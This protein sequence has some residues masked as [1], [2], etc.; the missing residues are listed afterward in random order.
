MKRG[1]PNVRQVIQSSLM[2]I[3]SSAQ[4]PLTVSNLTRFVSKELNKNVSWNTVEK[5][6]REL[7]E[8]DKIQAIT[9]PHSKIENKNGL[10]V[11]MLKK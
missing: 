5:Y 10:T 1:R 9:L 8:I 6:L 4:T 3:L 2:T 7:M 11:Y